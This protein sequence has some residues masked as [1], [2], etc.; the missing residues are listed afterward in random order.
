M[1]EKYNFDEYIDRSCLN[2]ELKKSLSVVLRKNIMHPISKTR[3]TN[4]SNGLLTQKFRT[5][6]IVAMLEDLT[7]VGPFKKL[8]LEG[9]RQKHIDISNVGMDQ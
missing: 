8:S 5:V 3:R 2:P 1:A 9:I 4:S 7:V 6:H